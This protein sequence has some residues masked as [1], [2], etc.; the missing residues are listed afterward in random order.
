MTASTTRPA[1]HNFANLLASLIDQTSGDTVT[2]GDLLEIVG[3]RS[4]GPVILVLG[5]VALS[6]LSIVPGITWAVAAVTLIFSVQIL[7]GLKHIWLPSGL[8]RLS[9][10]RDQ[11]KAAVR[12]GAPAAHVADRLTAPR[13]VFLTHP[14]FVVVTALVCVL[15]ALVTFPLGLVPLGPVLPGIS[16][17][18]LGVGM[19][20]RDG[21][22]LALSLVALIGPVVLLA[23]WLL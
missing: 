18:L 4:F 21:L 22:F 13:L 12:A 8:L 16:I 23:R 3:R 17:V 10:T 6:P 1:S 5:L 9:V 14:P 11:L 2:L 20:A 7:L 19:T 15:A